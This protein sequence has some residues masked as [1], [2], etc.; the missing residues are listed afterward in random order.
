MA[1]VVA[2]LMLLLANI[3]F[4]AACHEDFN[5]L[6]H[7]TRQLLNLKD[8]LIPN[9]VVD[10]ITTSQSVALQSASVSKSITEFIHVSQSLAVTTALIAACNSLFPVVGWQ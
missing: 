6:I 5:I 7:S 10:F 8:K 2:E 3:I 9:G 1:Q 4:H